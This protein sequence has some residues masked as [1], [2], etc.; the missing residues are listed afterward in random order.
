MIHMI[1]N[2]KNKL[3]RVKLNKNSISFIL[4]E[5]IVKNQILFN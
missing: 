2:N 4:K 5:L 1:N 3:K